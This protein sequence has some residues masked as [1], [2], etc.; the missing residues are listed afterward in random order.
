MYFPVSV[1]T[2]CGAS[3]Y[4]SSPILNNTD[5]VL[6]GPA[7]IEVTIEDATLSPFISK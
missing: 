5:I 3:V 6:L 2:S 1:I 7:C 4:P